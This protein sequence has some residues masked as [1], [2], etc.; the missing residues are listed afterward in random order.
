MSP[1]YTG[2][3]GG[4]SSSADRL[5]SRNKPARLAGFQHNNLTSRLRRFNPPITNYPE[6]PCRNIL[7]IRMRRSMQKEWNE[8]QRATDADKNRAIIV[9]P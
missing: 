1:V 6:K 7:Q 8:R 9:N 2:G 5:G 3:P 4:F